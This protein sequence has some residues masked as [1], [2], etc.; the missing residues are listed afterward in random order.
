LTDGAI[1][2]MVEQFASCPSP[3]TAMI[4]EHFHGE[5][6]R[7]PS[8]ATAVP[9][10]EPGYNLVITG[11]WMDPETT[12]ANVSWVRETY[13]ALAPFAV[14]RRWLNYLPAEEADDPGLRA[15]FGLN[16]E[17]LVELKTQYDPNNLFHLNA[18]IKPR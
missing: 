3:M 12:E 8:E 15:A 5:V 4:V 2:T 7:V 16:Y 18:N 11:V 9:H 13:D 17:R 6:T 14:S 10:R 1:D